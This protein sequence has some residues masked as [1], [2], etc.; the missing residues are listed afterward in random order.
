MLGGSGEQMEPSFA[1][2]AEPRLHDELAQLQDRIPQQILA[3]AK[4]VVSLI[5]LRDHYTASHS[6]RVAIYTREIT[7]ELGLPDD[8]AE[9]VIFAACLHDIGKAGISDHILLKPTALNEEEL[10]WIQKYPEWGWMTLRNID[11]FQRAALLVLHQ[12]EHVDG[13]GYP[14]GLRGAEI[15]LGSRIIAVAD[16]FDAL[17]NNR[18]YRSALSREAAMEELM[19]CSGTHFDPEIVNAFR[20][21]LGKKQ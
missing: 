6:A 20:T 4:A 3:M 18:P 7:A 12:H 19:R 21:V 14:N 5:G 16:S 8:E 11:G 10:A 17:T 2:H 1:A 9:T 15:P 13:S